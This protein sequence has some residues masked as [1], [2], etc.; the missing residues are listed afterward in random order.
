MNSV[1]DRWLKLAGLLAEQKEKGGPIKDL[2]VFDFDDT[3]GVTTSPTLVAA[4]EYNG[5]DPE[6]PES[7]TPIKDLRNRVGTV[8]K[9]LKTPKQAKVDSPGLSGDEV[10]SDDELDDSQAIVL[11]TEQYRDWKEKYIPSGEHVRPVS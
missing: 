3:L 10:K 9:G 8:V 2:H 11:D 4:V 7:Y 5:G 6:D 1:S